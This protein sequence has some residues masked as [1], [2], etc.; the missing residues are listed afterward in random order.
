MIHKYLEF[1][2]ERVSDRFN[3]NFEELSQF[4][5]ESINP[6]NPDL[7]FLVN[8]FK[9]DRDDF[10]RK[11]R[12]L[13]EVFESWFS[14]MASNY[15]A[16]PEQDFNEMQGILNRSGYTIDV[17]TKLFDPKVTKLV[18]ESYL[19]F[20]RKNHLETINGDVDFYLYKI[21][22]IVGLD[23]KIVLGNMGLEGGDEIS[24]YLIKYA[25]GYH[26]TPYGK[27]FLQQNGLT[28]EAFVDAAFDALKDHFDDDMGS[29]V[30]YRIER[31]YGKRLA[32]SIRD[33]YD[34]VWSSFISIEDDGF[35]IFYYKMCED[36]EK[37]IDD[38]KNKINGL[39]DLYEI[40]S[41]EEFFKEC[42]HD[43]LSKVLMGNVDIT[44]NDE[45]LRVS[46]K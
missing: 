3:Q 20:I 17:I 21:N 43:T 23:T 35:I 36:F 14:S 31:K 26:K 10:S 29:V 6:E 25:Y 41:N 4:D 8:R 39:D 12:A 19:Q 45:F 42:V 32:Y 44:D 11:I 1:I 33:S 2:N 38:N 28:I 46:S 15:N 18:G 24:E 37:F 7:R 9:T 22:E 16:N 30:I 13:S 34:P 27:L 40:S 5:I